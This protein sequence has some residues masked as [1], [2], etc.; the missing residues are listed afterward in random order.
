MCFIRQLD[1]VML[2]TYYNEAK[3]NLTK[4]IKREDY[5]KVIQLLDDGYDINEVDENGRTA[6]ILCSFLTDENKALALCRT[7]ILGG[8]DLNTTDIYGLMAIHYC[9][10]NQ[11]LLLTQELLKSQDTINTRCESLG[12]TELHYAVATGNL[13]LIKLLVDFYTRFEYST[14]IKNKSGLTPSELAN[15]LGHQDLI[16]KLRTSSHSPDV[17]KITNAPKTSI[18]LLNFTL[19]NIC[20]ASKG[21]AEPKLTKYSCGNYRWESFTH[22]R[23]V[24]SRMSNRSSIASKPQTQSD[25]EV[26]LTSKSFQQ[27]E[28]LRRSWRITMTTVWQECQLQSTSSYRKPARSPSNPN[29]SGTCESDGYTSRKASMDH[30]TFAACNSAKRRHTTY[31]VLQNPGRRMTIFYPANER[32][33]LSRIDLL[34]TR[35]QSV[36]V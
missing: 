36:A 31:G 1:A 11:K 25:Y 2:S 28:Q 19:P 20:S 9:C 3:R 27:T 34:R 12:N 17:Q 18:K 30:V 5:Y 16:E 23:S 21:R 33:A 26:S 24:T 22:T 4:A 8:A 15:Q 13:S 14:E 7:L 35:R 6:L 29:D 32:G 10:I